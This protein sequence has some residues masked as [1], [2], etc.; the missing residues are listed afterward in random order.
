[1]RS[2]RLM[3]RPPRRTF[4]RPLLLGVAVALA[5]ACDSAAP[6]KTAAAETGA[7]V[8]NDVRRVSLQSFAEL[9]VGE[10]AMYF[11]A[12]VERMSGRVDTVAAREVVAS[13]TNVVRVVD[14]GLVGIAVGQSRLRFDVEGVPVRGNAVVRE[15]VARDSVWL[16]PGEVRAWELRPGWH[17]ITV[18]NAVRP[19]EARALEL[20]ADLIC[21]PDRSEPAETIACRV[22]Q[23]T[24]VL[25]RHT[26][27]RNA[28]A[29]AV[30]TIYRTHR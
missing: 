22:T 19:G 5:A 15:R 1:M 2:L 25:L 7:R 18:E 12:Y 29:M 6:A 3:M 14:G 10:P 30:V 17:R 9:T 27:T 20:A 8:T 24:R 26:G 13:D 16:G 4:P 23:P 21:V 28:R 11:E